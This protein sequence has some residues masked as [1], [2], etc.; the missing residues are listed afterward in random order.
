MYEFGMCQ[1]GEYS[2]IYEF[3]LKFKS[4]LHYSVVHTIF[5]RFIWNTTPIVLSISFTGCTSGS[6]RVD[7]G[8]NSNAEKAK[9]TNA[10]VRLD[11]DQ[12]VFYVYKGVKC[13]DFSKDKNIIVTGGMDRI[14]R[15]WNPYVSE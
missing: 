10:R 11:A 2:D 3:S 5:S 7:Q 4:N 14:V 9:K 8:G 15:L 12:K 6:T 13:F 1:F